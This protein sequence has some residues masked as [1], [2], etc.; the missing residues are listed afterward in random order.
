MPVLQFDEAALVASDQSIFFSIFISKKILA[1]FTVDK[2]KSQ[3]C[4]YNQFS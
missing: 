2:E 3:N 4:S 1:V